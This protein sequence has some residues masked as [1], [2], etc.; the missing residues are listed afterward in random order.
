MFVNLVFGKEALLQDN[1]V[2]LFTGLL[3]CYTLSLAHSCEMT[4]CHTFSIQAGF[5]LRRRQHL[6]TAPLTK[7]FVNVLRL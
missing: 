3:Y 5:S 6:R 2:E 7:V 1:V 4:E